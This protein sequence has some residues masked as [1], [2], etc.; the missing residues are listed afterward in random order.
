MREFRNA[1]RVLVG[2]SEKR[3]PLENPDV[4]EWIMLQ[5]ILEK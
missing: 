5:W 2:N 1:Y 4:G 3:R